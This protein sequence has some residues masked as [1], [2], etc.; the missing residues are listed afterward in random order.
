MIGFFE[1]VPGVVAQLVGAHVM[2]FL[3]LA[4]VGTT[5]SWLA[6]FAAYQWRTRRNDQRRNTT[7]SKPGSFPGDNR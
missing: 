5:V 7:R 3:F 1:R 6:L 2:G 4:T